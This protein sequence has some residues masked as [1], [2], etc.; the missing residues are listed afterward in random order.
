MPG[1]IRIGVDEFETLND[2]FTIQN[3][4]GPF[5]EGDQNDL[6][7]VLM[8]LPKGTEGTSNKVN[9]EHLFNII[10]AL[11]M[12]LKLA[13][14]VEVEDVQKN[15]NQ[16]EENVVEK[17]EIKSPTEVKNEKDKS[18]N[19]NK[20]LKDNPDKFLISLLHPCEQGSH[21][22]LNLS[23]NHHKNPK[24]LSSEIIRTNRENTRDIINE[25]LLNVP[26]PDQ[27]SG[28]DLLFKS[29]CRPIMA[30]CLRDG[31]RAA[32]YDSLAY[33][34]KYGGFEFKEEE[35]NQQENPEIIM[36]ENETANESDVL[37]RN[38]DS[39]LSEDATHSGSLDQGRSRAGLGVT[40]QFL[41]L[42]SGLGSLDMIGQNEA[43]LDDAENDVHRD[44]LEQSPLKLFCT[45]ELQEPR[46]DDIQEERS[47]QIAPGEIHN[48]MDVRE[49]EI[50][51]LNRIP[52]AYID[53]CQLISSQFLRASIE[54]QESDQTGQI[55]LSSSQ[56]DLNCNIQLTYPE[57]SATSFTDN[58][59]E[60]YFTGNNVSGNGND[61]TGTGNET[62][63][64]GNY[65]E[66]DLNSLDSAEIGTNRKARK[67]KWY[68]YR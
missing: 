4:F 10:K 29:F 42:P 11:L 63:D 28:K 33:D 39:R 52:S 23:L 55:D 65:R 45:E 35:Q 36:E 59:S 62:A 68:H 6:K 7:A 47:S 27:R 57:T 15:A 20:D 21:L 19:D 51:A 56:N 67:N 44:I 41:Q 8:M 17:D 1:R 9:K 64:T 53:H 13:E 46:L 14:K 24:Q 50:P 34:E 30:E 5:V 25:N 58:T 66:M 54:S 32:A 60:S 12:Q 37:R 22:S 49:N 26:E 2:I 38:E 18:E 43:T 16:S 48:T 61:T 40:D 3:E 31:L